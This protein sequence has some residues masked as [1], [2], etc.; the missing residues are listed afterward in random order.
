[1]LCHSPDSLQEDFDFL[2]AP[3]LNLAQLFLSSHFDLPRQQKD[4]L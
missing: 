2:K 4:P 1:M 3:L